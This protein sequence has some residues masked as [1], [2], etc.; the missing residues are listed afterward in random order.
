MYCDWN[1]HCELFKFVLGRVVVL[2]DQELGASVKNGS[3]WLEFQPDW[4][5]IVT[6][7]KAQSRVELQVG[8]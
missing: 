6:L 4:K 8:F 3:I 1:S 2:L 5:L 7:D